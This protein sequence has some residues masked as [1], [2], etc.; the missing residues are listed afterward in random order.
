MLK[1]QLAYLPDLSDLRPDANIDDAIVGE[2][3]ESDPVEEE[4]LRTILRKHRTIFLDEG[5]ALPPPVRGVVCD[6]EVGDAKPI[7]M[8]SRRIPADLLSKVYEL[9]KRLLKLV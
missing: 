7:S 8:R 6:L 4:R 2:P 3:G 9:L 5:N 1:N